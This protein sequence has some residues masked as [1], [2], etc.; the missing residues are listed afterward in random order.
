MGL[1][2]IAMLSRRF[3]RVETQM[4]QF[5]A[6]LHQR[7]RTAATEFHK[8][9]RQWTC[10]LMLAFDYQS[11]RVQGMSWQEQVAFKL[12]APSAL[13]ESQV[14]LFVRSVN[15]VPNNRMTK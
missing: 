11:P 6:V 13:D 2:L 10:P 7:S 5:R 12:C 8:I 9:G 14:K 15:L 3:V 4:A 1:Q